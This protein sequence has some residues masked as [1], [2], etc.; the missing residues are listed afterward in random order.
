MVFLSIIVPFNKSERY[1]ID[2]L[3]SL[4]EQNLE[5]YE[6]L[7][8]VNGYSDSID[9]LLGSYKDLNI[10]L[11]Q[12]DEEIGVAKARNEGLRQASG[13]YIYFLDGDDYIYRDGLSKLVDVA[14]STNADFINGERINT[15]SF[16][17]EPRQT[18]WN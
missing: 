3:D 5:D 13:E 14:R 6:I 4:K 7:L 10:K 2:C 15:F 8:I 12:F 9:D 17:S 16:L 1:L 11:I 18:V